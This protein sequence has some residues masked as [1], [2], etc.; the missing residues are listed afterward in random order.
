MCWSANTDYKSL[1]QTIVAVDVAAVLKL[2]LLNFITT[3]FE[4]KKGL[5]KPLQK[6]INDTKVALYLQ[7]NL[8]YLV[9]FITHC[10]LFGLST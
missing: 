8:I 9:V 2:K 7:K 1:K 3:F 10:S 5:I 6:E 4:N